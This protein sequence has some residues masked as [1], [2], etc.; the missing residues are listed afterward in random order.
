MILNFDS[1]TLQVTQMIHFAYWKP[2]SPL[3]NGERAHSLPEMCASEPL[4]EARTRPD[5][6][7][8]CAVATERVTGSNLQSGQE[9]PASGTPTTAV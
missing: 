3:A 4:L 9:S 6:S 2:S 7:V 8:S 5:G 1:T